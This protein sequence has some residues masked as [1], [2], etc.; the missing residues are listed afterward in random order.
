L[1]GS[2]RKSAHVAGRVVAALG[3]IA[4]TALPRIGNRERFRPAPQLDG[5]LPQ[6]NHQPEACVP[7]EA[8]TRRRRDHG[9]PAGVA[10]DR[11]VAI[12]RI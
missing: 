6:A 1:A 4:Q 7:R 2:R 9:Q 10:P 11:G 3:A 5:L 12:V 8:G